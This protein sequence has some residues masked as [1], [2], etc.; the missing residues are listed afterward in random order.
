M[1]IS[2]IN[3][4]MMYLMPPMEAPIIDYNNHIMIVLMFLLNI[5][6]LN[7]NK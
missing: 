5:K 1:E 2:T 3:S 6:E 7:N 4:S